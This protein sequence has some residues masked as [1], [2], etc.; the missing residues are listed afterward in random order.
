MGKLKFA[1]TVLMAVTA[2]IS[3]AK[4]VVKFIGYFCKLSKARKAMCC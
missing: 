1:E 3:A 4:S 2:V